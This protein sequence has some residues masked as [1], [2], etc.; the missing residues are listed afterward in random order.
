MSDFD[1]TWYPHR[2]TG[3]GSV[4]TNVWGSFTEALSK[5]ELSHGH[6]RW[7]HRNG[8]A[9][10]SSGTAQTHS[11][12]LWFDVWW[13]SPAWPLNILYICMFFMLQDS[14]D[15]PYIS[16]SLREAPK[17]VPGVGRSCVHSAPQTVLLCSLHLFFFTFDVTNSQWVCNSPER[18]GSCVLISVKHFGENT[19]KNMVLNKH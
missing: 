7:G 9:G 18:N 3:C 17:G 8:S 6:Q 19:A 11:E 5:P 1:G 12:S 2:T 14:S 16:P 4:I 13:H 10:A 15:L